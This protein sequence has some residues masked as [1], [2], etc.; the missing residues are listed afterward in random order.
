MSRTATTAIVTGLLL[1]LPGLASAA[2]ARRAVDAH[3]GEITL[4][5]DVHARPAYR[6]M[7]PGMAIIADP[8]PNRELAHALG[9][10]ELSDAEFAGLAADAP[11]TATRG[12]AVPLA[13][14]IE[15]PLH[16]VLGGTGPN[17][18]AN[19]TGSALGGA[20]G[21]PLNAVG[22]T[23]RGIG[24]HVKGALAQFPMM[25]TKAGGP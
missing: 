18:G 16:G 9:T 11:V 10:G 24:D 6:P 20:L 7:P 1:A 19:G 4:L 3:H 25:G 21:V 17:G 2:G 14:R 5:R 15:Q 12:V 13:Q 8:T 23:T 22:N